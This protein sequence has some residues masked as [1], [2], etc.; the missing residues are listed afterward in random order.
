MSSTKNTKKLTVLVIDDDPTISEIISSKLT[1]SGHTAHVV[2]SSPEVIFQAEQ[3]LP[4]VVILDLMMTRMAGEDVLKALKTHAT[5]SEI[6][7]L[8]FS[9]KG[10]EDEME[11]LTEMGAAKFLV[12]SDTSLTEL[13]KV[14]ED[15]VAGK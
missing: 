8:I 14:V 12:K 11:Y 1:A 15:L 3:V 2:L 13:V 10:V 4:D 7:V 6:P 5:L 9:N